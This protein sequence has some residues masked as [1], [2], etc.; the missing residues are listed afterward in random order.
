M[1]GSVSLVL[2]YQA[3]ASVALGVL[4]EDPVG[5][6]FV[7]LESR[8][9]HSRKRREFD[10]SQTLEIPFT[11]L[12]TDG[13]HDEPKT[14]NMYLFLNRNFLFPSF[15]PNICVSIFFHKQFK[16]RSSRSTDND[17]ASHQLQ[18]PRSHTFGK[19]RD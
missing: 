5:Q 9:V 12:C 13:P 7:L 17:I 11:P 8:S 3:L 15:C 16:V 6:P 18:H 4:M 1:E 10:G 2:R 19:F 14:P